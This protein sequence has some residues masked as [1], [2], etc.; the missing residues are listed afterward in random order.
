MAPSV[1]ENTVSEFEFQEFPRS[2]GRLRKEADQLDVCV[3]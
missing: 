1:M 2:G 3:Q